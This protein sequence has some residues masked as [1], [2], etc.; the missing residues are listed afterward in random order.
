MLDSHREKLL[1]S[2]R[3]LQGSCE[4]IAK[5]LQ[6]R[7]DDIPN[8]WYAA[9]LQKAKVVEANAK[10]VIQ[11]ENDQLQSEATQRQEAEKQ[12]GDYFRARQREGSPRSVYLTSGEPTHPNQR[13]NRG[14]WFITE[15]H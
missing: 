7:V 15:G 2:L 1:R 5:A 12:V 10:K 8:S 3:D 6:Q 4:I 11:H 13:G 14:R 9:L